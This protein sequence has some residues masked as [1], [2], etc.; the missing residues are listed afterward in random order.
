MGL[1]TGFLGTFTAPVTVASDRYGTET[2]AIGV[3]VV[4]VRPSVVVSLGIACSAV[5]DLIATMAVARTTS[6][7]R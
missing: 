1:V 6:T 5:F 7:L 3:T 4:N 2:V